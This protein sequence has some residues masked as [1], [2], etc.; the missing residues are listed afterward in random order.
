M[1]SNIQKNELNDFTR[2]KPNVCF[3]FLDSRCISNNCKYLHICKFFVFSRCT[4]NL[5]KYPHVDICK[6]F[7]SG[8]CFGCTKA[9]IESPIKGRSRLHKTGLPRSH[10]NP[11]KSTKHFKSCN[12]A[13]VSS[14][15]GGRFKTQPFLGQRRRHSRPPPPLG[16]V[17][18]LSPCILRST[19]NK[20]FPITYS[21]SLPLVISSPSPYTEVIFPSPLQYAAPYPPYSAANQQ[22]LDGHESLFP[23]S[24]P[25]P[26]PYE[27]P[28]HSFYPSCLPCKRDS[29]LRLFPSNNCH[30]ISPR[31]SSISL[32]VPHIQIPKANPSLTLLLQTIIKLN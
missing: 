28:A 30:I 4:N 9:H 26:A 5:C 20:P 18:V 1:Q 8:R 11:A 25:F 6:K 29:G 15:A 13:H 17:P 10:L 7:S 27:T 32:P 3:N 23:P 31:A 22:F 2:N 12:F 19:I 16:Q 24:P 14:D 21:P